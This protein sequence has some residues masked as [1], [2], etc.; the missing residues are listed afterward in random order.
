MCVPQLSRNCLKLLIFHLILHLCTNP[1][2]PHRQY[3][4]CD[5]EEIN[6]VTVTST[7]T[8]S[9]LGCTDTIKYRCFDISENDISNIP[10]LP[11]IHWE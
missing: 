1:R 7:N 3:V 5:E 11:D 2:E 4:V 6:P 9:A 8:M 10:P